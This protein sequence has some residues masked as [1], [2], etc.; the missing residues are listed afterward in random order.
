MSAQAGLSLADN[1][2][3]AFSLSAL[4]LALYQA[5]NLGVSMAALPVKLPALLCRSLYCE[6]V[7]ISVGLESSG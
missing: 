4:K 1:S 6:V 5:R 3:S 2:P 7:I